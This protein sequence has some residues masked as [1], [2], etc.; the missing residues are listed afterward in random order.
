MKSHA[1]I[2]LEQIMKKYIFA[3]SFLI[4]SILFIVLATFK[5]FPCSPFSSNT[6]LYLYSALIQANAAIFSIIGVFFIFR[7]QSVQSAITNIFNGLYNENIGVRQGAYKFKN[8]S[9]EEKKIYIDSLSGDDH[10][11]NDY[12]TWFNYEE[13][14]EDNKSKIKTPLIVIA[15]L[16]ILQIIFLVISDGINKLGF[17]YEISAFIIIV[18]FQIYVL[19]IVVNSI[20]SIINRKSV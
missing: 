16:I 6:G 13:E 10:I 4:V 15:V 8:M 3:T 17:K 20:L 18:S 11:S 2:R 12:R 19:S 9:L 7:L 14:L 1:V 5:I